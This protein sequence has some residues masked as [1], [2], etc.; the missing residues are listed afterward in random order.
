MFSNH[1]DDIVNDITS[2]KT[3]LINLDQILQKVTNGHDLS[4]EDIWRLLSINPL[5]DI[6]S[7]KKVLEISQENKCCLFHNKIFA[8]VPVYVTSYCQEHCVYCNFRA[9]NKLMVERVRLTDDELLNEVKYLVSEKGLR[10]VE[11]VYA[12]DP[13][14]RIDSII[15]HVRL[16][17]D[18]V[19]G[20]H[21][22]VGINAEPFDTDEYVKLKEGGLDFVVL[23]QETYDKETYQKVHIGNTKKTNFD[24]RINAFER[25]IEAGLDNIGLGV[26]SGLSDWRRDWFCLMLHEKYLNDTY[27]ITP[28]IL[29]VPRL[30]PAVGAELK[31]TPYMLSDEEYKLAIAIHNI[32]SPLCM[33]F[34]NTREKWELCE[35]ISKGGGNLFTFNCSTIPGGYTL[36]KKGY[37]FPTYNF[38]ASLFKDKALTDGFQPVFDWNFENIHENT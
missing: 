19:N 24:Y 14:V 7:Y 10:V 18:I 6:S 35:E 27:G 32:F 5:K 29:G 13:N 34:V 25:M 38:D 9:G 12:T 8:I 1:I 16:V 22:L 30:K 28:N 3:G 4:V 33:P 23:W 15:R 37:Q 2:L 26:L 17:K 36:G 20:N 21:G 11:L 31:E